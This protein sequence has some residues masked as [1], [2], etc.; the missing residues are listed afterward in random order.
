MEYEIR[1]KCTIKK[2]REVARIL[3]AREGLDRLNDKIIHQVGDMSDDEILNF[4]HNETPAPSVEALPAGSVD[5]I[6]PGDADENDIYNICS[7]LVKQYID[8]NGWD[9]EKISPL[10]WAACC[11]A[12]G[13]FARSRSLFRGVPE[14][15]NTHN[16]IKEINA[17]KGLNIDAITAGAGAWLELCYKYN[18]APLICDFC[19]FVAINK[20]T[21]Y[22]MRDGVTSPR[23][24][25]FKRIEQIEADG[26][27][28]R[29]IDPKGS[30][31]GPMFLL[32]ADHGLIEATKVTHEYI[33]NDGS[34]AALPV[35][36]S[37]LEEI[38][39]KPIK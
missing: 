19:E 35:F 31:I 4:L 20:Q 12:V 28:R 30:P 29:V 24:E 32:K 2:R 25:L 13:R 27:R 33:K 23:V 6:R 8:S 5:E 9:G 34:A 16:G 22:N 36:G 15:E 39:E 17:Q 38:S 37:N 7:D 11:L 18:K 21:F 10:Q 26:L 1:E 3:A 14:N